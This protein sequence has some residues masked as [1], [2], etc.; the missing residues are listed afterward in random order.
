MIRF[1]DVIVGAVLATVVTVGSV[2]AADDPNRLYPDSTLVTQDRFSDEIVGAGPDLVLIPGLASSRL[3]WK[4]TADRL[5]AHYRLHLIQLAGFSGEPARANAGGDVLI[6]TAEAIDAY[7]V[8]QHL[9]PATVI[10]HSLG[11]T[12]ALYLAA[13]HGDHLNKVLLVDTLPFLAVLM[14]G[15][16]AT[17]DSMKPIAEQLRSSTQ[18]ASDRMA[19]SLVTAPDNQAMVVNWGH[20]SDHGVVMRAMADDL[21]LDLRPDLAKITVPV[22]L[23][24]PDN[25]RGAASDPLYTGAY[26]SLPYATLK[27]IDGSRHFIMLDQPAAFDAA[28]DAFLKS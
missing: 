9:A 4:A 28:L 5:K 24:Y 26:A 19:A 3:T 17:V 20:L 15:P 27:R 14:A 16:N 1:I 11:G 6:P 12:T 21:T 13:H 8:E 23:L 2:R 25:G 22:T 10:G 7:L 18:P